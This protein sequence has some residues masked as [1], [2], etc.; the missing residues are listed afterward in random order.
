[1]YCVDLYCIHGTAFAT[2]IGWQLSAEV[3]K[4]ANLYTNDR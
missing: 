1:M 2:N 3:N 4:K